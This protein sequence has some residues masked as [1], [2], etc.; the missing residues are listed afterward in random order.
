MPVPTPEPYG[1]SMHSS[2]HPLLVHDIAAERR[3]DARARSLLRLLL[4]ARRRPAR[5]DGAG[6]ARPSPAP[7]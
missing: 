3:R 1:R 5:G 2:I 6:A 7:G 4:P